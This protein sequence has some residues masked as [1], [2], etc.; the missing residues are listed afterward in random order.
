MLT[1]VNVQLMNMNIFIL[2]VYIRPNANF[3]TYNKGQAKTVQLIAMIIVH[4]SLVNALKIY[5]A[6]EENSRHFPVE[7]FS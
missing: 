1:L 7:K 3:I 2:F 5:I 6:M 4:I